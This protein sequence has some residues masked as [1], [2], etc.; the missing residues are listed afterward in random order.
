MI[1]FFLWIWYVGSW[2]SSYPLGFELLR[3]VG[4]ALIEEN[5]LY[6]S[7]LNSLLFFVFI[8]AIYFV[9]SLVTSI[10]Y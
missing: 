6:L 1:L 2:I 4:V 5:G 10:S 8:F 9:I 7:E 3:K